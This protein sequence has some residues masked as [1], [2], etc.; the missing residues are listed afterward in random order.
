MAASP[1]PWRRPR[2]LV[3]A[4]LSSMAAVLIAAAVFGP[5]WTVLAIER[6]AQQYL[7][8]QLR[9]EGPVSWQLRPKPSL[10][11]DRIALLDERGQPQLQ[12]E[13][14][15]VVFSTEALFSAAVPL[16]L[17]EIRGLNMVAGRDAEGR[18]NF[19][20]WLAARSDPPSQGALP[21]R[22]LVISDGRVAVPEH[23]F[24]FDR[25]MVTLEAADATGGSEL[26]LSARLSSPTS[27]MLA[28][29]GKASA[30]LGIAGGAVRLEA[31]HLSLAGQAGEWLIERASAVGE[32]IA[33]EDG[34]AWVSGPIEAELA[35]QGWIDMID[36]RISVDRFEASAAA[37]VARG[38]KL[39]IGADHA[40]SR[41][42]AN[43]AATDLQL[44]A[45][46]WTLDG[47][48]AETAYSGAAVKGSVAFSGNAVGAGSP[49]EHLVDVTLNDGRALLPHPHDRAN[50]LALTFSGSV[51]I[52][53]ATWS[54]GGQLAGGFDQSLF[55]LAWN[56]SPAAALTAQLSIDRLNLDDYLPSDA[57]SA[58]T[59]GDF[60]LPRWQDWPVSAELRVGMLG[61]KGVQSKD[62][63]LSIN[64][65]TSP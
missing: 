33:L 11:L 43:L 5:G 37:L 52:D 21:L 55:E 9:I 42:Q 1:S 49:T 38:L 35:A 39:D 16:E 7:L 58:P 14:I 48:T 44:V 50:E 3:L 60:R 64:P 54:A 40:R 46:S 65:G 53:P 63:R 10:A 51:R 32:S 17:L 26:A 4:G 24:A 15:R 61:L 25:I 30:R 23:E 20:N 13:G 31:L 12:L 28:L 57:S 41:I 45:D 36:A 6:E 19:T 18:W 29:D 27:P 34:G 62:V 56:W 22:R 59:G 8:P 47:L 2:V